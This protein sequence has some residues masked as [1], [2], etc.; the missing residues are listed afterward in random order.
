MK[1]FG[2][3]VLALA[4]AGCATGAGPATS[5]TPPP[6]S[7]PP[8][9][10]KPVV[11][12]TDEPSTPRPVVT[13]LPYV[14]GPAWEPF[15]EPFE[16]ERGRTVAT[17]TRDGIRISLTADASRFASADGLWLT[18]RLENRGTEVLHWITD[19]CEINVGVEA[20]TG[21]EW[22]YGAEQPYPLRLFK[23]WL[24]ERYDGAQ[25]YSIGLPAMPEW[26]INKDGFGCADLGVGHDLAPGG[27]LKA[28]HFVK[29]STGTSA[30]SYGLPPAGPILITGTFGTW[31]RGDEDIDSVRHDFL[32]TRLV[33]LL[34]DGRDPALISP[35]QAV[36]VAIQSPV[37]QGY[38]SR[39]PAIPDF[40]PLDLT[41]DPASS[42]WTVHAVFGSRS[43]SPKPLTIVVDARSA[44]IVEIRD[45]YP[46]DPHICAC[47]SP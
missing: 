36:D 30:G 11:I 5:P 17:T 6:G 12:P 32:L 39:Y 28:R 38:L 45:P 3:I 20:R 8:R 34:E 22:A 16:Y 27:V 9:T 21:V 2:V 43:T 10:A 35:G 41:F 23:D 1:P 15:G 44:S 14:A 24:L 40:A 42:R 31:W 37:L 13:A 33:V 26:A 4:A 46:M 7:P 25:R 19:G 18:T 29:A 47:P